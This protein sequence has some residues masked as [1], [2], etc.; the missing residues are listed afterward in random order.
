MDTEE[1]RD[2]RLETGASVASATCDTHVCKVKV[3]R[4]ILAAAITIVTGLAV[5]TWVSGLSIA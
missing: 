5:G 3:N 2:S 4:R 1:E